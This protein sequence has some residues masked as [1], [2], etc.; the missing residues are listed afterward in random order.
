MFLHQV[1]DFAIACQDEVLAEQVTEDINKNMSIEIKHLG[2]IS[3]YNRIDIEQ[4]CKCIKLHH[5]IHQQAHIPTFM[6]PEQFY[7]YTSIPNFN[8]LITTIYSSTREC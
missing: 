2:R 6:A 1:D 4:R 7:T 5:N 8:E 3:R